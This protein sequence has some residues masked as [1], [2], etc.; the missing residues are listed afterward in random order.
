MNK[1]TT[2]DTFDRKSLE[3]QLYNLSLKNI[4]YEQNL[5]AS[6]REEIEENV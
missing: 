3:F 6:T 4:I 5:P 2:G 1:I